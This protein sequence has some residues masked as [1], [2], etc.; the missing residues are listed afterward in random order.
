MAEVKWIKITTTMFDD[1][2]IRLI[3]AMPEKDTVLIIWIKLLVL[4]GKCNNNGFI[5]LSENIPYTEEMLATLFNRQLN[6]IR[7]ALQ[8]FKTFGMIEMNDNQLIYIA[9]WDKHQ[10]VEGMEKIR[11]QTKKRVAKHREK[12]KLLIESMDETCGSLYSNENRNVTVTLS[13]ATEEEEDKEEDI[14]IEEDNYL[15]YIDDVV[16]YYCSKAGI[17]QVNFKPTEFS[18]VQELL[19]EVPVDVIKKGIDEAFKKYKPKFKGEKISSFNY[20]KPVILNLWTNINAKNKK[21]ATKDG[22]SK[23]S[24][25][26]ELREQGI[27]L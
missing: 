4:A 13:N 15:L 16:N 17:L 8:T 22:S 19:N 24:A 5:Y 23:R 10:N 20:C 14:D 6:T 26:D 18:T 7:M 21:G 12:K 9:N 1:E 3:E 11:E 27:G 2:K 25:E